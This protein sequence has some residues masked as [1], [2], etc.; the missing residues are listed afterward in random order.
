MRAIPCLFTARL[1]KNYKNCNY[2]P[3]H[4]LS[5]LCEPVQQLQKRQLLP[6]LVAYR[7]LDAIP[8]SRASPFATSLGHLEF[9]EPLLQ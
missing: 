7:R 3:L 1:G 6:G 8:G 4:H 9:D 5:L 2:F